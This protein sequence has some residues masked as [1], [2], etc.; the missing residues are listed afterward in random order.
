[1]ITSGVARNSIK[2]WNS[3]IYV[4]RVL[5][6]KLDSNNVYVANVSAST[7]G[8]AGASSVPSQGSLNTT[9]DS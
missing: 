7:A 6:G 3:S 2:V 5:H 1:M 4:K 8:V 9:N